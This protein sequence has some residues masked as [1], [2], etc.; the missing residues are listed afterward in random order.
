DLV[1]EPA[2][3]EL[4]EE[5]THAMPMLECK[6][7]ARGVETRDQRHEPALLAPHRADPCSLIRRASE[8]R[9]APP[10]APVPLPRVPQTRRGVLL[11]FPVASLQLSP[12]AANLETQ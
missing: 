9:R 6:H 5:R 3:T 2:P 7:R 10:P 11:G 12:L 8:R 1:S 4:A